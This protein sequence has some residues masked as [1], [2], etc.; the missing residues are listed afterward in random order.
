[1]KY[2]YK[3]RIRDIE[4][5]VMIKGSSIE[6]YVIWWG[7]DVW[8]YWMSSTMVSCVKQSDIIMISL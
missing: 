4:Y 8:L 6:Y 2:R 3:I 5:N 7:C 1:M